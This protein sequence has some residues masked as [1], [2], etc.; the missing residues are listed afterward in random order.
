MK[1]SPQTL[2]A[3]E[4]AATADEGRISRWLLRV[5]L[6]VF[7]LIIVWAA[8]FEIDIR[9]RGGGRVVPV[10][11][12]QQIQNLEG[13]IVTEILVRE[14]D[15]V[16]AGQALV[17]LSPK[18]A[19][20]ELDEKKST[21]ESLQA[22]I[23]RL[24]AEADFREAVYPEG[25]QQQHPHLVPMEERLRQER[26]EALE[27]Q[28]QVLRSQRD[29]KTSEVAEYQ[30]RLPQ[31]RANLRL[32]TEQIAALEPLVR[33]GAAAGMEVVSLRRE[34]ANARAQL[35]TAEHG[36]VTSQAALAEAGR[37]IAEKRAMFAA[38]AREELS[39]RRAQLAALE[40]GINAKTDQVRRTTVVAPMP[41]M[42][43]TLAVT[44][45]GG[46][47]PPGRTIVE[48]VPID[49]NLLI[50]ARVSPNEIAWIRPGQPANVRIGA[51]DYAVFGVLQGEVV[52]ISPDSVVDERN[53]Q[54]YYRVKVRTNKNSVPG[55]HGPLMITPGM[56]A[57][58]DIL[59]GRRTVL[60]YLIKPVL[61]GLKSSMG[62][63]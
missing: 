43:K 45:L 35:A 46:V 10:S 16:G 33:S 47:T 13:G 20:G 39:R 8:L 41:G 30:A 19:Q 44:T 60:N 7:T 27:A 14:G 2:E 26:R 38:E 4:R 31:V 22:S 56:V 15:V 51:F 40:G 23:V 34:E 29:Q 9:A 50:E 12:V 18:Q 55:P 17:R 32:L 52:S 37:R 62:E 28:L 3:L 58:V 11:Q 59:T 36:L 63:R 24:E 25:L 49:D 1:L 42:I 53:N 5:I 61:R 54:I 48:L 21:A 6:L 57:E